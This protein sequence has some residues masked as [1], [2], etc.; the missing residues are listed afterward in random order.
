MTLTPTKSCHVK[1]FPYFSSIDRNVFP[2]IEIFMKFSVLCCGAQNSQ[3][4]YWNITGIELE[5]WKLQFN[6]GVFPCPR[7]ASATH[8][9]AHQERNFARILSPLRNPLLKRQK[10]QHF[11]CCLQGKLHLFQLV[12]QCKDAEW[13]SFHRI[14]LPVASKSTKTNT[15]KHSNMDAL[16]ECFHA[17]VLKCVFSVKF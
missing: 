5:S 13:G 8:I 3:H 1:N 4:Q 17:Y 6:F 14:L 10:R 7:C 9:L 12:A 11:C 2:I 15:W 16:H